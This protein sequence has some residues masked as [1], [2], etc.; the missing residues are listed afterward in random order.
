MSL[1]EFFELIKFFL[2]NNV[3]LAI[4]YHLDGVYI[5][6]F[7]KQINFI[8]G[9]LPIDFKILGSAHNNIEI[10]KKQKQGCNVIFVSPIFFLSYLLNL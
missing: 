10:L 1:K 7:N 6:A 5:P 2:S 3:N 9:S 8:K 4:K